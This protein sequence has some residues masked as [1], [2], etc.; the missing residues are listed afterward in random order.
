METVYEQFV[1]LHIKTNLKRGLQNSLEIP[2]SL[3]KN[4]IIAFIN[5]RKYPLRGCFLGPQGW[6][7]GIFFRGGQT[8]ADGVSGANNVMKR[9]SVTHATGQE[10]GQTSRHMEIVI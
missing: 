6:P 1:K 9:W 4:G 3:I 8:D 10:D 5:I 7:E 2:Q